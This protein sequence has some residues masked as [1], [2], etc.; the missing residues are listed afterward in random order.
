MTG[1]LE[2]PR[3]IL[4]RNGAPEAV[5]L[6]EVYA[7]SVVMGILNRWRDVR[8]YFPDGAA[9][10]GGGVLDSWPAV[11]VNGFAILFTEEQVI[12]EVLRFFKERERV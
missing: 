7:H 12:E 9:P 5:D 6:D 3:F 1:Q 2:Q 4:G 8:P 11:D 10:Y